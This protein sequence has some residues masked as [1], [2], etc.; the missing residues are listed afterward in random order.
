MGGSSLAFRVELGLKGATPIGG[1]FE[2]I[3][4]KDNFELFGNN[5][6]E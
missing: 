2:T 5:E 1:D 6:L 3:A 4:I